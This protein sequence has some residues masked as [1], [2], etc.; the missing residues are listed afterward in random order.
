MFTW[1]RFIWDETV[2]NAIEPESDIPEMLLLV[3]FEYLRSI[4]EFE[5]AYK[6]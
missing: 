6:L 3:K 2:I 1:L 5:V 4:I